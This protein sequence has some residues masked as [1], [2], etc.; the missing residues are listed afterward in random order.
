MWNTVEN[1]QSDLQFTYNVLF[2]YNPS[3]RGNK[4]CRRPPFG[5]NM[6]SHCSNLSVNSSASST[7]VT[8]NVTS[9]FKMVYPSMF[10][11]TQEV[12]PGVSIYFVVNIGNI[13]SD[14]YSQPSLCRP[15]ELGNV[16]RKFFFFTYNE[17]SS[18]L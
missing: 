15:L 9:V 3:L 1:K 4:F 16:R 7:V 12:K 17:V 2:C 8:C 10:D 11:Y 6:S 18:F 14:S 13:Q 5:Y